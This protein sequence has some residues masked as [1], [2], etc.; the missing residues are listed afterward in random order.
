MGFS[1]GLNELI[2]HL[3]EYPS[4]LFTEFN[5]GQGSRAGQKQ[6]LAPRS[7]GFQTLV[8][9]L[10]SHTLGPISR[11]GKSVDSVFREDPARLSPWGWR[12]AG[13]EERLETVS[14]ISLGSGDQTLTFSPPSKPP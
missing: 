9:A 12:G 14:S 1:R 7:P 6:C 13:G 3:E 8:R 10:E 5:L 11:A 4:R 2:V